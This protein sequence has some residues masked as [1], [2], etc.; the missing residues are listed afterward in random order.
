MILHI[1]SVSPFTSSALSECLE[2]IGHQDALLL[3][4][5]G[6]YAVNSSGET[7]IALQSLA[8]RLFV[9]E[10]DLSARGLSNDTLTQPQLIDHTQWVE[11]VVKF[12]KSLSWY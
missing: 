2:R 11:L 6:V 5:E 8:D 9:L 7:K 1:L 4:S 3:I 10:S 12:P